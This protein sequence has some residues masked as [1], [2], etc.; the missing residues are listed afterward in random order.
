M[1]AK[2]VIACYNTPSRAAPVTIPAVITLDRAQRLRN[3]MI[4]NRYPHCGVIKSSLV[5]TLL[6]HYKSTDRQ[7]RKACVLYALGS[8]ESRA[9]R[10]AFYLVISKVPN[11]ESGF[12]ECPYFIDHI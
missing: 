7:H 3:L 12:R 8:N 9:G 10:S 6:L 5:W 2:A 4:S 1:A 11:K